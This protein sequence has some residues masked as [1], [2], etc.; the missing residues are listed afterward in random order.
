MQIS[1]A[2][3]REIDVL[4][5]HEKVIG[6]LYAAYARRFP[7]DRDFW[8]GLS[9]EEE[10]HA[11]WIESLQTKVEQEPSGLMVNRF[12][13]AAVSHSIDYV[14]KLIDNVDRP[15]LTPTKAFSAALDLERAL[16]ENRY[17]EIFETDSVELRR[18]LQSL[19]QGTQGHVERVRQ[20]WQRSKQ[21]SLPRPL[22]A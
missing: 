14:N 15:D 2:V 1:D 9:Q 19:A 18:V 6:R 13:V 22:P 7:Q 5:E 11:A 10:Q 4:R 16:L 21:A 20:A 17:F 8:L 3:V 12:P